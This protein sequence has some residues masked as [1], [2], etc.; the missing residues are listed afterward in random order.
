MS[1]IEG[2]LPKQQRPEQAN[3][4]TERL[5]LVPS[6]E[7]D[8]TLHERRTLIGQGLGRP[9]LRVL[10]KGTLRS[11][12][13]LLVISCA[14]T[15]F[16]ASRRHE[17]LQW[18]RNGLILF[19]RSQTWEDSRVP[20]FDGDGYDG[21]IERT[22]RNCLRGINL[23][24]LLPT[25]QVVGMHLSIDGLA[26]SQLI[27]NP[28]RYTAKTVCQNN[29]PIQRTESVPL[30]RASCRSTIEAVRVSAWKLV[31]E[32]LNTFRSADDFEEI[33]Q[34]EFCAIFDAQISC[35]KLSS[36]LLM[37]TAVTPMHMIETREG[38]RPSG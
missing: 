3:L 25:T 7:A 24:S 12:D 27:F 18:Q 17:A 21:F 33:S 6:P 5:F 37:N 13:D 23:L 34:Q 9:N 32:V 31:N 10:Q 8:L 2:F 28:H 11:A 15:P 4:S 38:M 29:G 22:I 16:V 35:L 20:A 1:P 30:S 14:Y 36:G 26:G 19:E